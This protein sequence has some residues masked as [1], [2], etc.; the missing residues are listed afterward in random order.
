M[1]CGQILSALFIFLISFDSKVELCY[2]LCATKSFFDALA[3]FKLLFKSNMFV[4]SHKRH[5]EQDAFPRGIGTIVG[6]GP[7]FFLLLLF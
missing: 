2:L 4:F 6:H 7:K 5:F 1:L 3:Y